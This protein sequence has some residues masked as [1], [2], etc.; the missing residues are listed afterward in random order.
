MT[1]GDDARP[2][3][4]A[5]ANSATAKA[6]KLVRGRSE[7]RARTGVE[8]A[9]DVARYLLARADVVMTTSALL[10]HGPAHAAVLLLRCSVTSRC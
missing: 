5:I 2:S 4:I 9:A 7:Y 8:D 1:G 3:R 10:R 6:L